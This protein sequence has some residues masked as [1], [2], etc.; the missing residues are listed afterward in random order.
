MLNNFT[1]MNNF[2]YY[3]LFFP[4]IYIS[5]TT[6]NYIQ[7]N[8]I[9]CTNLSDT[10]TILY[11]AVKNY[12]C[13]S[14]GE[15]HGTK[16]PAEFVLGLVKSFLSNNRKVILG[17]E[18]ENG[19]IAKFSK[20]NKEK[21]IE[22]SD[23]F[24]ISTND[25]RNSEAWYNLIKEV[26]KLENIKFCFFDTEL[27]FNKT[28]DSVMA[29]NILKKYLVDTNYVII[30]LTGNIHN[31]TILHKE[32]KTMG[33]YLKDYFG[34]RLT[35]I[36]NLYGKGTMYNNSG[37][38]LS[39]ISIEPTNNTFN[40]ATNYSNFFIFNKFQNYFSGYSAFIFTKLITASLTHK[41]SKK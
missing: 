8:A 16:E 3:I 14:V 12:K 41:K 21:Y 15:M 36:F 37:N 9:N 17:M 34:S 11:N 6:G 29:S 30:T 5:Q 38:G 27:G 4:A 2:L 1:C 33:C 18:I 7:K 10:N 31:K 22:E 23:F 39:I 13:I 35:S 40:D 24:S 20:N 28:R 26:N 32:A 19:K 25:G